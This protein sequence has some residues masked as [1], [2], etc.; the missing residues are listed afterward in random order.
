M[1]SFVYMDP[2]FFSSG[3]LQPCSDVYSFGIVLLRLLTGQTA[4]GIINE[5]QK[6]VVKGSL[7]E[8]LDKSAGE[9]PAEVANKIAT[10]GMKCC[11]VKRE[12]RPDL[13]MHAWQVL[14]PMINPPKLGD[15]LKGALYS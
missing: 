14:E 8:I 10:L 6:A 9:W 2:E 3:E 13:A 11:E 1:G 4:M 12:L 15:F 7:E 5:V